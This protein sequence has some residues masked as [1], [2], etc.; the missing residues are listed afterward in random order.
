MRLARRE[1]YEFGRK[2]GEELI[3]DSFSDRSKEAYKEMISRGFCSKH[4]YNIVYSDASRST[5]KSI[6]LRGQHPLNRSLHTI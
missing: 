1:V 2:D 3:I 4:Y 6:E 5:T